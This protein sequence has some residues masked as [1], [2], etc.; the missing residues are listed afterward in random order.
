M[1]VK[2][3]I[4]FEDGGMTITQTTD[5]SPHPSTKL[6]VLSNVV[7]WHEIGKSFPDG[8]GRSDGNEGAGGAS[9]PDIFSP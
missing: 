8:G 2:Y 4:K 6:R 1:T 5:D 7:S 3:K 9:N